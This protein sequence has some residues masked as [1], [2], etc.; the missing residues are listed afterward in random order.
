MRRYYYRYIHKSK[1]II[2][3]TLGCIGILIV[4]NIIPV[5]AILLVVGILLLVMGGLILKIK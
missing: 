5:E 2:G 1:K 4:I 3:I